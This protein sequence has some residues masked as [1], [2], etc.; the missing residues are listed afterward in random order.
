MAVS[1][2]KNPSV[3]Q[4]GKLGMEYEVQYRRYQKNQEVFGESDFYGN[5]VC[6]G[7]NQDKVLCRFEND[8]GYDPGSLSWGRSVASND[9]KNEML[10][11]DTSG[12]FAQVNFD[13]N[14]YEIKSEKNLAMEIGVW[15]PESNGKPYDIL[16][17][18][19]GGIN[20]YEFTSTGLNDGVQDG[21]SIQREQLS[22]NKW[23]AFSFYHQE[24]YAPYIYANNNSEEGLKGQWAR[25]VLM[26]NANQFLNKSQINSLSAMS[27]DSANYQLAAWA[28][29]NLLV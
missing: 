21:Y 8:M 25:K 3:G 2:S 13:K 22:T 1:F 14:F 19:Q 15:D 12:N 6:M 27:D 11:K 29:Q 5:M 23:G 7:I 4:T 10:F 17:I 9:N 28:Y 26:Q 24:L 20:I 18:D 16:A